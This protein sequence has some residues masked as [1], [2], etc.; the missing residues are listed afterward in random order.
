MSPALRLGM[1][2]CYRRVLSRLT[3]RLTPLSAAPY[4][5]NVAATATISALIIDDEQLAR[6]ELKYLLED[7][8]RRGSAG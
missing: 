6:E 1:A 7:T 5:Q 4:T 8:R 2:Q 3:L